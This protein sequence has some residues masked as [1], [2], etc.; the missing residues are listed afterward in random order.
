MQKLITIVTPCFNEEENVREVYQQ[1]KDV[2]AQIP[3]YRYEHIFIDNAST[4][5][6]ASILREI[7]QNDF[8]VKVIINSRNFG[9]ARSPY[10]ALMQSRG[11]ASIVVMADLQDPPPVIKDLVRKWEE[12]YKVVFAI[13][14]KSEES[15]VM[16]AIRKFYYNLYNKVS[17]IQIVSNYC[18]FGLYDKTILDILRKLD[19]P[20]PDIR[21]LLGEIGFEKAIVK[22]VQPIRKKGK[23]K[24]NFYNLYD[25]AML[26]ITRDSIIP[27]RIASFIG[28]FVAAINFMVAMAY[29][30]YKLI[31]WDSF[32]LGMAP[33]IIGIFFFGGVQ[34]FFLGVIGEYIGAIFTQVKKRP[35]V[36]EK[37]RINFD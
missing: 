37:E 2:F 15:S 35:L 10:H 26:G 20:C 6:T 8:N 13:K 28:F 24:N 14:E 1:V 5:R 30:I 18:G 17:N 19:D 31:Y 25:Q 29:F 33:M 4:D 23:S 9:V 34:L 3:A 27:L 7:A 21:S 11:D 36:I 16:F 22:Y 12:G 32:Q